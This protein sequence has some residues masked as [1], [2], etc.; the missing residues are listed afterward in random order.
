MHLV[1]C[2]ALCLCPPPIEQSVDLENNQSSMCSSCMPE[3]KPFD[4]FTTV[5]GPSPQKGDVEFDAS[6]SH[7]WIGLKSEEVRR[8]QIDE[9]DQLVLKY[10]SRRRPFRGM[11]PPDPRPSLMFCFIF[12]P[13][14][15]KSESSEIWVRL[16]PI[17]TSSLQYS[18]SEDVIV[19][20]RWD[21][22]S[23]TTMVSTIDQISTP[24][25]QLVD[26]SKSDNVFPSPWVEQKSDA[27]RRD[28]IR[29]AMVDPQHPQIESSFADRDAEARLWISRLPQ[30]A[31]N[32][33]EARQYFLS[34]SFYFQTHSFYVIFTKETYWTG[35]G[36]DEPVND[37]VRGE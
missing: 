22:C 17:E 11:P 36:F 12:A 25:S 15:Q 24:L 14:I 2:A 23:S 31:V 4:L 1:F 30:A 32:G 26:I 7:C 3:P 19:P 8:H 35:F 21:G 16:N 27:R 6:T 34:H 29:D 37:L 33:I 18:I 5:Y 28:E 10:E 13:P 9:A 20:Y